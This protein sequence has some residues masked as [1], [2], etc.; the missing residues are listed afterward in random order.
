MAGFEG[1]GV[2]EAEGEGGDEEKVQD[3]HNLAAPN[4]MPRDCKTAKSEFQFTFH[5]EHADKT[6]SRRMT[7]GQ[8]RRNWKMNTRN[9]T[10]TRRSSQHQPVNRI[11]VSSRAWPRALL[12]R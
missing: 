1:E 11:S 5:I 8:T 9:L 4:S 12:T 7:G 6:A 3:G 10:R 2:R